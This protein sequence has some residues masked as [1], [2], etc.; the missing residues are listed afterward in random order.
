MNI[1]KK[2]VNGTSIVLIGEKLYTRTN[3]TDELW[4][5]MLEQIDKVN[6][7]CEDEDDLADEMG[8][9]MD[10]VDPDRVEKL[11][12][13]QQAIL[14]A[15]EV[16]EL[17]QDKNVRV[18]K[19][20]R[21]SDISGIFE[22][23]DEGMVYLKGFDHIMPKIMVDAIL[24]AHYNPNSEYTVSSLVNFWKYL[25]LNPD[26]HVRDGLFKWIKSGKFCI[27][28]DGN[29]VSYRN[30]NIKHAAKN[31]KLHDF[32]MESYNKVKRW[33]K[34]VKNYLICDNNGKYELVETSKASENIG[35]TGI[36]SDLYNDINTTITSVINS[37]T[38]YQPEHKG[39]YG[40]EIIIGKPV[41]M[42][43]SECDNNPKSMCSRGLHQKNPSYSLQLGNVI[44][45]CLTNPYNVVAIPEEGN[46][47]KF[48]TCEYLPVSK[49]EIKDGSIVEFK[50]GTYDIPYNG[51]ASLKTLLDT[52]SLSDLKSQGIVSDEIS[53]DDMNSVMSAATE[54]IH[55]RVVKVQ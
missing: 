45:T 32:V 1:L 37:V 42:P 29:I 19:A 23:D 2:R 10:L 28:E 52:T 39:P 43:R 26:K 16:G 20:K 50:P 15:I 24:D 7:V 40:Q 34:S 17:E 5:A 47:S 18:R 51:I 22:C 31:Q 44:L 48:R 13:R 8:K 27:T 12:K 54:I 11:L 41:S 3:V 33:K 38:I 21:V 14:I 30:V 35:Y 9:L 55:N 49:T 46:F 25:L 6:S 53:D 4:I 36:L